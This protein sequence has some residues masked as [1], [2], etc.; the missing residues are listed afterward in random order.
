MSRV[1]SLSRCGLLILAVLSGIAAC[2]D[3]RDEPSAP[4]HTGLEGVLVLPGK[5]VGVTDPAMRTGGVGSSV[6]EDSVVL[7]VHL[8][9]QARA[10]RVSMLESLH[11]VN[12][13]FADAP[14][15]VTYCVLCATGAAYRARVDGHPR[16][17]FT[18]HEAWGGVMLMRDDQTGSRW[19]QLDGLC[20]D[21]PLRGAQ[22]TR[23]S[24][25][26]LVRW[27]A[28]RAQHP[29]SDVLAAQDESLAAH[30]EA[31]ARDPAR[32][33][34]PEFVAESLPAN[35]GRLPRRALVYG[36]VVAGEAH[37][38]PLR[39]LAE[40]SIVNGVVGG[41][42][43]VIIHQPDVPTARVFDR[44]LG[45]RTLD[46]EQRDGE[47]YDVG[48]GSRWSR[49]GVAIEGLLAGQQLTPVVGTRAQ[50]YAWRFTHPETRL[51]N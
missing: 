3:G 1:R 17:T 12:D 16:L 27:A 45:D 40:R 39:V 25:S 42:P 21:G 10:Y 29:D 19:R 33:T 30:R 31:Q 38:W 43:L 32:T 6:R 36:F 18:A 50:W 13:R 28:W 49:D 7:G 5:P 24:S 26:R 34:M 9:G 23:V 8:E 35:D 47:V 20:V 22:L 46:F 2:G 14:V 48:T 11:I 51:R 37:A 4:A 41:A 15:A 44:R